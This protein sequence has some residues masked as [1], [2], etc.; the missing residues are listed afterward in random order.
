MNQ[1]T[2]Y[3]NN[4]CNA[5]IQKDID[6]IK[7]IL[8]PGANHNYQNIL[9]FAFGI[10]LNMGAN[11]FS[12]QFIKSLILHGFEISDNTMAN[13]LNQSISCTS[14]FKNNERDSGNNIFNLV[15][16]L[17]TDNAKLS[18][19]QILPSKEVSVVFNFQN[20]EYLRLIVQYHPRPIKNHYRYRCCSHCYHE[21]VDNNDNRDRYCYNGAGNDFITRAIK[22]KNLETVK[23]ACQIAVQ[24]DIQPDIS[25][26]ENNSLTNAVLT[27][28]PE[29][30]KEIMM[31]GGLPNNSLYKI[32]CFGCWIMPIYKVN[33]NNT[34]EFL[35]REYIKNDNSI[36]IHIIEQLIDLIM[37]SGAI[38][39]FKT[40]MHIVNKEIKN[41]IDTKIIKYCTHEYRSAISGF[42]QLIT[43]CLSENKDL[44]IELKSTADALIKKS[45]QTDRRHEI[46]NIIIS[47]PICCIDIIFEYQH[48][49]RLQIINPPFLG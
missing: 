1:C 22:T 29:I 32:H 13:V 7:Y 19:S 5:V 12:L 42:E 41:N 8:N 33:T 37:C 31:I 3:F 45:K 25:E 43:R 47:I 2:I 15:Q 17:I 34:F 9:D 38:L 49:S 39:T 11:A 20:P 26:T 24:Y 6:K 46:E 44:Q 48:D 23:V 30:V 14:T 21:Y 16:L 35:Y 27:G 4:P 18:K 28:D 40:F 10:M 36:N